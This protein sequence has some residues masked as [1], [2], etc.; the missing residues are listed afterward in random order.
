M[1]LYTLDDGTVIN[2]DHISVVNKISSHTGGNIFPYYFRIQLLGSECFLEYVTYDRAVV[3]RDA[4][5][6]MCNQRA[7]QKSG[8]L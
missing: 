1:K 5:I 7:K 3:Q 8:S 2:L 6:L 4:L